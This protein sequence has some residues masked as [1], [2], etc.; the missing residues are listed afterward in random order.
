[1]DSLKCRS[2]RYIIRHHLL[3]DKDVKKNTLVECIHEKTILCS[4]LD[5]FF[6][7]LDMRRA[8]ALTIIDESSIH[9]IYKLFAISKPPKHRDSIRNVIR[10]IRQELSNQSIITDKTKTFFLYILPTPALVLLFRSIHD[11]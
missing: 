9:K 5:T 3:V 10:T 2:L 1:M 8:W 6:K 11:L 4:T 7:C